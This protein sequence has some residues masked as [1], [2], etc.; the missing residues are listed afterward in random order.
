MRMPRWIEAKNRRA[1]Q[2][3]VI[4]IMTS[5]RPTV[6]NEVMGSMYF[7]SVNEAASK[8]FSFMSD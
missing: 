2:K 1:I 6:L 5:K 8:P 3:T 4:P 7:E